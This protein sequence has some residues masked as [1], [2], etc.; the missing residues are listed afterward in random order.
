[1]RDRGGKGFP[2]MGSKEAATIIP[3]PVHIATIE[4]VESLF[5]RKNQGSNLETDISSLADFFLIN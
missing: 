1:M 5:S 2:L 4:K 3:F